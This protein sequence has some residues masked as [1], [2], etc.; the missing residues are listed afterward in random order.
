MEVRFN[1]KTFCFE[2]LVNGVW[3]SINN[4]THGINKASSVLPSL[5]DRYRIEV[6]LSCNLKCKYCV[7]HTNN[8]SQQNTFMSIETA[9][10]IVNRY[11]EEV[12]DQ[13][14]IFIMGG[15]PLT[16]L[17]TVQYIIEHA[18]GAS[19]VFTNALLLDEELISFFYKHNTYILTSLDGYNPM[20]NEKR[21]WPNVQKNFDRVTTNIKNAIKK[22]CKVGVSCLM[23]RDNLFEAEKIAT[24]FYN[25]LHAQAMS[26]AYPHATLHHTEESD[27]DFS[28]YTE[29]MKK[30]YIF[31]KRHK[32]YID[33]IGKIVSPLFY[34]NPSVIGCKAGTTQR[35]FYPDGHETICTKIDT[36]AKFSIEQYIKDLPFQSESCADCIA[37]Y[38]CCGECPWD[39]AIACLFGKKHERICLYR[40]KLIL[41]I[42]TDICNELSV[43]ND[44]EE[45]NAVFEETFFPMAKNL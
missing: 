14:S 28:V 35:T 27:F 24:Y 11:N 40:K 26:F 17:P 18:Q 23:H 19:I 42:I 20:Q 43:A 5:I 39:Y 6:S 29:Q 21:F 1:D 45:A 30:L 15:E 4:C 41:H 31:S 12:G 32:I 10:K 7:V 22:G 25:E 8:V 2:C 44:L 34:N 37:K 33:Q 38:I 13:G 16:N 9:R 3:R 36:L